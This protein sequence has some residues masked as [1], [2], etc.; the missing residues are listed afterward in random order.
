MTAKAVKQN[1]IRYEFKLDSRKAIVVHTDEGKA[2]DAVVQALFEE[3]RSGLTDLEE[4]VGDLRE[5]VDND[6]EETDLSNMEVGK[7]EFDDDY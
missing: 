5:L 3:Y 4:L 6:P 7:V 1:L 2:Q